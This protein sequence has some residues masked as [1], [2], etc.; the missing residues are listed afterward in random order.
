MQRSIKSADF[1]LEAVKQAIYADPAAAGH[2]TALPYMAIE[3][4]AF[5]PKRNGS[6]WDLLVG[7]CDREVAA[8]VQT[9]KTRMQ[10]EFDVAL[11]PPGYVG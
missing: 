6:N 11:R 1:I 9:A 10:E 7:S 4:H 5:G 8:L 2:L 3:E